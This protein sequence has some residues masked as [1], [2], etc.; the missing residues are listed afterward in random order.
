MELFSS[1]AD[2]DGGLRAASLPPAVFALFDTTRSI[3]TGEAV[4]D[5][6]TRE[7]VVLIEIGGSRQCFHLED[8]SFL[9][10]SQGESYAG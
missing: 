10:I 8:G 4:R 2:R 5:P 3:V 9:V 1:L 7:D 6:R